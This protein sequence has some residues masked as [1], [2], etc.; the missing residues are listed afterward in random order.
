MTIPVKIG[1]RAVPACLPPPGIENEM[2]DGD[3]LT[4][5]GWGK[6]K[7]VPIDICPDVLYSVDVP[8]ITNDRCKEK[9][10]ITRQLHRIGGLTKSMLCAGH[11]E[12]GVDA[13]Q[14]ESGGKFELT[15]NELEIA[16]LLFY[17]LILTFQTCVFCI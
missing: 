17:F 6:L 9:S 1:I 14:G 5:S 3:V 16:Y 7:D 11:A 8:F 15:P 10:Y 12:G 4:V 13:C 2:R